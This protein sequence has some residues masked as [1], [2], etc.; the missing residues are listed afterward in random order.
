MNLHAINL[1]NIVEFFYIFITIKCTKKNKKIYLFFPHPHPFLA[2]DFLTFSINFLSSLFNV[3]C[4]TLV[5]MDPSEEVEVD[6]L[7]IFI[8][9]VKIK[10]MT[11]IA[12]INNTMTIIIDIQKTACVAGCNQ[13]FINPLIFV[14]NRKFFLLKN[15]LQTL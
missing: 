15:F 4:I 7:F 5:I 3:S 6:E 10:I 1:K 9:F 14:E 12:A 13:N 2:T 8:I 11:M